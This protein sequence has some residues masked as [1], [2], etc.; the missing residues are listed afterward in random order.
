MLTDIMNI[1]FASWTLLG[2][3]LLAMNESSAPLAGPRLFVV[4]QGDK[5]M[6]V[7]DPASNKQVAVIDE[8]QTTMHGHEI[9]VG[10]D[11]SLVYM[12]I[13]GNVGVG[14]PGLDGHEMLVINWQTE[15]IVGRIDFG[16]GGATTLRG[17][18]EGHEDV[19]C[20]HGTR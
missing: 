17:L 16:H 11:Q 12:P 3:I 1:V 20:D 4:N 19:V 14:S 15:K 9:A 8:E 6:S 7:I 2:G 18:F 13:Y 5:T 10:H